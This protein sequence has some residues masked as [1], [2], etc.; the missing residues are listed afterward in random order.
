MIYSILVIYV[1]KIYIVR[2]CETEGNTKKVFQGHC[3][4]PITKLGEAQLRALSKRFDKIHLDKIYSSPLLR[5]YKTAEAL[6]GNKDTEIICYDELIELNGGVLES[7]TYEEIYSTFPDFKDMWLNNTYDFA[8]ENGETMRDGYCRIWNA[9]LN[10]AQENAGKTIAV[11]TH[12]GMIRCLLTRLLEGS[13]EKMPNVSWAGNTSVS[14]VEFDSDFTPTL[15]ICDDTSHLGEN[16]K[17][18]NAGI[19]MGN[20]K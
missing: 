9:I 5:A 13:V 15:K 7:K 6:K 17:N 16:L 10:I 2:H 20:E 1:T 18:A 3:D 11:A 19:P 12:G 14:L 4:L 8:P